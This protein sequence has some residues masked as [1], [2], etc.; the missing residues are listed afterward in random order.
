[1]T[2]FNME[3]VNGVL[4]MNVDV[5]KSP[6]GSRYMLHQPIFKDKIQGRNR[7]KVNLKSL[8]CRRSIYLI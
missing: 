2:K 5:C 6:R 7:S 3:V 4:D 1:M 8:Q